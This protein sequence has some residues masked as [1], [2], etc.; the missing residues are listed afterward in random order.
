VAD[1]QRTIQHQAFAIVNLVR[2]YNQWDRT[3]N[4]QERAHN[5][6]SQE[7][8]LR[9]QERNQRSA[10]RPDDPVIASI[11]WLHLHSAISVT[12]RLLSHKK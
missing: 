3:E 1:A 5:D 7:H 6:E 9:L 10:S 8:P 4:R 12:A 2:A 11:H